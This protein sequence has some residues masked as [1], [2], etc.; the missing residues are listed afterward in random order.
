MERESDDSDDSKRVEKS[1]LAEKSE[2][3]RNKA[4]KEDKSLTLHLSWRL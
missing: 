2:K 3:R 1:R 4:Y